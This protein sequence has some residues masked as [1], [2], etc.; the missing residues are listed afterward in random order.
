M[1]QVVWKC[2]TQWYERLQQGDGA[3]ADR[4]G[5]AALRKVRLSWM[6]MTGDE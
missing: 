4:V 1:V 3:L 5:K 6:G 2:G